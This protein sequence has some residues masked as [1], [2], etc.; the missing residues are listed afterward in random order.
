[1]KREDGYTYIAT[2]SGGKDSTVMCDLLLK[3]GYPVDYIVFNDTLLEH[4]EMYQYIDKLE[5]YFS[6]RYGKKITR[7]KPTKNFKEDIVFHRRVRDSRGE[8]INYKGWVQGLLNPNLPFCHWRG[9]AKIQPFEKYLKDKN[10]EKHKIYIGFTTDEA[11]RCNREN[12]KFIYPLID[13]FGLNERKCAEYLKKQE[14]QNPLYRHFTRT[15]CRLCPYQSDRQ[16]YQVWK[17]Y[18]EVWQELK[19]LE[20]EV[21]E[22]SKRDKVINIYPF[23]SHRSTADMERLFAEKERQGSLFDF[24]DEPL[25]DCFCKI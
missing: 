20:A 9:Y 3:N 6:E 24:S 7:L 2:L 21:V 11:H 12:N 14:M 4:D 10:I 16:W 22:L 18:P 19:E 8:S 23:S 1:M 15:G 25:K 5:K 13:Y 17:H